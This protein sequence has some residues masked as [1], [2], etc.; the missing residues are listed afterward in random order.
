[1]YLVIFHF[2]PFVSFEECILNCRVVPSLGYQV[3]RTGE[4]ISIAPLQPQFWEVVIQE[5]CPLQLLA[6]QKEKSLFGVVWF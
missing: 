2:P 4:S 3:I 5:N 6:I 1:M